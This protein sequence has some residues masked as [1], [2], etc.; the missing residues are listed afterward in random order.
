ME[1]DNNWLPLHCASRGGFLDVVSF[2]V[3]SGSS[4]KH[5]TSEE[6]IPVWY[7][8]IEGNTNVVEFLL[9]HPHETSVLLDDQKLLMTAMNI[10]V[11]KKNMNVIR[12][13]L[14]FYP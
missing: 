5:T 10:H 8:C 7:A 2:L 1:D 6:K 14:Y 4:T 11:L 12:K 3:S 13:L 9:R